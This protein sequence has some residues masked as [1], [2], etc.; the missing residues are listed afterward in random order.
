VLVCFD[1]LVTMYLV[2]L[3]VA[4]FTCGRVNVMCVVLGCH[5]V[6]LDCKMKVWGTF[7][8]GPVVNCASDIGGTSSIPGLRT[9]IPRA[10]WCS[11]KI[12]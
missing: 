10:V 2:L 8:G 1:P 4:V 9:K 3:S 7:P 11:Q 5:F 6:E 12:K